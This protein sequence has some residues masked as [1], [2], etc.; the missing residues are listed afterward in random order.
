MRA[1]LRVYVNDVLT[2][3][4]CTLAIINAQHYTD[5]P[6]EDKSLDKNFMRYRGHNSAAVCY[7]ESN[8]FNG[9]SCETF[10][11]TI[12]LRGERRTAYD[13]HTF[14]CHNLSL[15][16]A[17]SPST[18]HFSLMQVF[19]SAGKSTTI[20]LFHMLSTFSTLSPSG[21]EFIPMTEK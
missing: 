1:C 19:I 8:C 7:I 13:L 16:L 9:I 18:F 6:V 14:F 12:Q 4:C 2:E 21:D 11:T 5:F 17:P 3:V 20:N 15:C 10:K